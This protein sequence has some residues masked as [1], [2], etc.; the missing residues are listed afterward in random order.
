MEKFYHFFYNEGMVKA[1]KLEIDS[2]ERIIRNLHDGLYLTDRDRVITYWNKAAEHITGFSARDVVG[3]AC[4]DSILMHVDGEGNRLCTSGCPLAATMKDGNLREADVYLHHKDGYRVPVSVRTSPLTDK[5]GRII[6]GIEVFTD[7]RDREATTLKLKELEQLAMLDGL[8]RLANR[9]YIEQEL[10]SLLEEIKRFHLPF[11]VLFID[12]DYFKNV[13]DTYGHDAGDA[14]LKLTAE[15]FMSNAR[16]F[17]L[18]GRWGGEEFIGILRNLTEKDLETLG[19]RMRVLIENSHIR[20][21]DQELSVTVSL[22]ATMVRDTDTMES[23]IKRVDSLLYESKKGGR[24]R[25]TLG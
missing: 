7:I 8:T 24:N 3:T 16:P 21:E 5:D 22:G 2:Y 1:P 18:Y 13:N 10:K 4:S 15:T 12:I 6:G 20:Y 23:L 14:V 9:R 11:G 19:N 17:D 25:L